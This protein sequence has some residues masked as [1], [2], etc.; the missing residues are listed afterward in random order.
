MFRRNA[1]LNI[2]EQCTGFLNEFILPN[3][4]LIIMSAIPADLM[5]RNAARL[6]PHSCVSQGCTSRCI[7]STRGSLGTGYRFSSSIRTFLADL[8]ISKSSKCKS[9]ES[10]SAELVGSEST[11]ILVTE[12]DNE[13]MKHTP[14]YRVFVMVRFYMYICV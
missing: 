11:D 6:F 1:G 3:N 4:S 10:E 7:P 2:Y 12:G 5:G 13:V 8:C 14:G 9:S